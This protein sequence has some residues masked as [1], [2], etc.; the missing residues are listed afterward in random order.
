MCV[1]SASYSRKELHVAQ[2]P[3]GWAVHRAGTN[4]SKQK[5]Y[6]RMPAV[7]ICATIPPASVDPMRPLHSS[8]LLVST[9]VFLCGI[10]L[11]AASVTLS[12]GMRGSD[13][14]S[15]IPEDA[16]YNTAIGTLAE[17]GVIRGNPDGTFRP[18][19]FVTRADVAV[20]LDRLRNDILG[21]TPSAA[22]PSARSTI[23]RS[24]VSS[25]S[26]SSPTA[27][28]S[29]LVSA[30][31]ARPKANPAGSVRFTIDHFSVSEVEDAAKITLVRAG[32]SEGIVSVR[33][34][35]SDG[36][37][38]AGSD[39][40]SKTDVLTFINGET[41]RLFTVDILDDSVDEGDETI[42]IT[43]S[44]PKDGVDLG[45]PSIATLTIEDDEA[46]SEGGGSSQSTSSTLSFGSSA[47]S[48]AEAIGS[49]TIVVERKGGTS[50]AASVKYE[51]KGV[52]AQA[53]ADFTHATGELTFAA[54][55]TEK[56][57]TVAL[58]DDVQTEGNEKVSIILSTPTGAAIA[59]PSTVT[60][61]IVDDEVL[62]F[63][64]GTLQ[65]DETAYD[66][67][68]DGGQV[69]LKVRRIGG[70]KGVVTVQYE[71]E[72]GNAKAGQDYE[73]TRGTLTF[74]EG[75]TEKAIAVPI[76][77]DTGRDPNESFRVTLFDPTGG[78]EL[79]PDDQVVVTI[80]E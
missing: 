79:G 61:I 21:L 43:L 56:S 58:T 74:R 75:E 22:Q 64:E 25:S 60:L 29:T 73:E 57:F 40:V 11:G 31:P 24:L 70:A 51:T 28:S 80:R 49:V 32:G 36:T 19:A 53:N 66:A 62:P 13:R 47:Y 18:G 50:G 2:V 44:D 5:A 67:D 30:A 6:S 45:T 23:N 7:V 78:A 42:M 38:S 15:D 55:E 48:M 76:I 10:S 72:N 9:C 65:F 1:L 39:Y 27:S 37:A 69:V 54:G 52:T 68:E 26:S 17:A 35:L 4:D 3:E 8:R 33:Y 41:T 34:T 59:G 71:T 20:M 46:P 14:F 16:Y 12:A 63:T 77:K